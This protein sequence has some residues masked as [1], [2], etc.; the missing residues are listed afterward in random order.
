MPQ[1]IPEASTISRND[2]AERFLNSFLYL[3]ILHLAGAILGFVILFQLLYCFVTMSPP[4]ARVTRFA[5][6]IT[7]YCFEIFQYMTYN[8]DQSPFPFQDL[9]N[10]NESHVGHGSSI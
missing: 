8:S 7:R 1:D 3:F 2:T 9:P 10:G 6:R 4:I 5:D